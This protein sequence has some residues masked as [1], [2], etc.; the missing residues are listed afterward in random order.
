MTQARS[1]Q[2]TSD[3]VHFFSE[4]SGQGTPNFRTDTPYPQIVLFDY[5][6]EEFTK[7]EIEQ[8]ID[9]V[10]YLERE[11]VTWLDVRGLGGEETWRQL[12]KVFNLHPLALEDIIHVPQRPHVEEYDDQLVIIARMITLKHDRR[13]FVSEQVS[14]ILGQSYL[15][16]VQEE[17]D[18]DC[19]EFV[20]SRISTHKSN[21]RKSGADY[22]AY[23]LLDAIIDGFFPVLEMY[24]EL[25]ED[26]EAEVI[27]AP[28]PK[29]LATIYEIKR[30][31]L[32]MRRAIWPQRDVLNSLIRDGSELISDNVRLYLRDSY[33]HAVQVLDVVETYRELASSLTDIYL[34]SVSNRMNEVMKILTIISSIFVPLT[35]VAGVYGMNFNTETSPFNMPELDWY[36]GYVASLGVML[37]IAIAM[38]GFFWRRG[39][40][41][42]FTRVKTT[43]IK[44]RSDNPNDG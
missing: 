41:K 11:S 3:R 21:L 5:N 17:P 16:T 42:D 9:C 8:P 27:A 6:N 12:Q 39:W 22:L 37:I 19:L 15:V 24:G 25:I 44:K 28:T 1:Y 33:D 2:M 35:F 31:L 23:V 14:F 10:P 38:I 36:W 29:T 32:I 4:H 30:E 26:L 7:R 20:R 18:Y 43:R 13:G 34:S 40:F